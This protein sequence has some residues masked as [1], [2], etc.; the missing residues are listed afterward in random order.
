MWGRND[1]EEAIGEEVVEVE[2]EHTGS[3][4]KLQEKIL[5]QWHKVEIISS[6]LLHFKTIWIK[7]LLLKKLLEVYGL[8]DLVGPKHLEEKNEGGRDASRHGPLIY[9]HKLGR[10]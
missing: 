10:A 1:S 6:C 4:R 5:P 9:R 3:W 2:A 8:S 7:V